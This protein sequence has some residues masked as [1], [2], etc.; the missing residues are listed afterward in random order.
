MHVG[1]VELLLAFR[2]QYLAVLRT[3]ETVALLLLAP[4][5]ILLGSHHYRGIDVC[6][7]NLRADDI[8][9]ERVIINHILLQVIR[10]VEVGRITTKVVEGYRRD[11]LNVPSGVEERV[12]DRVFIVNNQFL[13]H[14]FLVVLCLFV[15][16]FVVRSLV[17]LTV[18]VSSRVVLKKGRNIPCKHVNAYS[19]Q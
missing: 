6:V 16:V 4:L 8:A 14:R 17:L 15:L 18:T 1:E 5:A 3:E 9:V 10:Q 7:A 11:A 2:L 19:R 13:N 12:G